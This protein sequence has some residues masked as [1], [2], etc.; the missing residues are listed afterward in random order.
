MISTLKSGLFLAYQKQAENDVK[1]P[2]EELF[3]RPGNSQ[4]AGQKEKVP[5]RKPQVI[6]R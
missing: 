5:S 6:R 4:S 3:S 1:K 2:I